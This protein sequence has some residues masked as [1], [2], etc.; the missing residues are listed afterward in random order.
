[1]TQVWPAFGLAPVPTLESMICRPDG[2]VTGFPAPWAIA[3][4][5]AASA[6]MPGAV[7]RASADRVPARRVTRILNSSLDRVSA[8]RL[9]SPRGGPLPSVFCRG[10]LLPLPLAG[11]G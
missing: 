3:A 10:F 4:V 8:G 5:N 9:F 1:M 11:E 7:M 2:V 6:R